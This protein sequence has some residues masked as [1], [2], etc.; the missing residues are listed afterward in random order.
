LVH[1]H[2]QNGLGGARIVDDLV[3]EEKLWIVVSQRVTFLCLFDPLEQE[4]QPVNWPAK[5]VG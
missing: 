1:Q 2:R 5:K 4:N 3:R